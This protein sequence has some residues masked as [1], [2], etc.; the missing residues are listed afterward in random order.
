[1]GLLLVSHDL[2]VVG[3]GVGPIAV[4]YAGQIVEEGPTAEVLFHPHMPYTAGLSPASGAIGRRSAEFDS[5]GAAGPATGMPEGCRFA[6]RCLLAAEACRVGSIPRVAGEPQSLGALYPYRRSASAEAV[7]LRLRPRRGRGEDAFMPE[8]L[9]VAENLSKTYS[10]QAVDFCAARSNA[11]P[12][13]IGASLRLDR[14]EILGVVGESGSGKTTLARC[15]ALLDRPDTGRV[16]F[17][18]EDLAALPSAAHAGPAAPHPDDFPGPLCFAQSAHARRQCTCGGNA[19]APPGAAVRG[20][21]RVSG[22]SSKVGLPASAASAY[23]AAFSGGQRQRICIARALAAE[24]EILIADE[25][26]SSLDVSIQAQVV[27]LLLDSRSDWA[28]PSSSSAMT[29]SW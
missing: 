4:M 1:M 17:K 18:G 23:P 21:A 25:P 14:G 8:P 10:A 19:G 3:T 6:P 2:A 24:P 13:L 28:S 9:L 27:N 5:R 15:L 26:V 20:A 22:C 11:K 16:I 12:A 29:C 7:R